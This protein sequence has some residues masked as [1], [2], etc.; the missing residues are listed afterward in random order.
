MKTTCSSDNALLPYRVFHEDTELEL[1]IFDIVDIEMSIGVN[2]ATC[3]LR[4]RVA[5]LM[6]QSILNQ[7]MRSMYK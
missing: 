5:T 6:P 1:A 3:M 2:Q 4:M 7:D